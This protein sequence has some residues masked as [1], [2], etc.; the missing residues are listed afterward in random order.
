MNN[1]RT[2]TLEA[3]VLTHVVAS[4]KDKHIQEMIISDLI[5][6][7]ESQG[8]TT[9]RIPRCILYLS[10]SKPDKFNFYLKMANNDWRDVIMEAEYDESRKKVRDFNQRFDTTA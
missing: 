10:E 6:L 9:S 4:F 2:F 1:K 8:F 7:G 3:D 5:R